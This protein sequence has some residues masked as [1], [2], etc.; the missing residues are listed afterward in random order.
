MCIR[1]SSIGR[2][3]V[4][5]LNSIVKAIEER[6]NN[7]GNRGIFKKREP[8]VTEYCFQP[9]R[10]EDIGRE[11]LMAIEPPNTNYKDPIQL[12]DITDKYHK[13]MRGKSVHG[14]GVIPFMILSEKMNG[15]FPLHK[16]STTS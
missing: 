1:D 12:T 8:G 14:G 9:T 3:Y 13:E 15:L 6:R 7:N 4:H 11:V 16:P 2:P 5:T 10:R